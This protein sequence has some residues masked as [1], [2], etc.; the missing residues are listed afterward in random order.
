MDTAPSQPD[1]G[2]TTYPLKVLYVDDEDDIREIAVMA[3]ELDPDILVKSCESGA[4]ALQAAQAWLPD[5]ILLDVMMPGM[6][7][8]E[9]FAKLRRH[10]ATLAIPVVFITARTQQEDIERF[11]ALGAA[12]VIS[13]PFDPM[14]L[15]SEAKNLLAVTVNS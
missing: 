7:G 2:G 3:L 6:D 11:M 13:K 10:P 8:P 9:T 15:A 14:A 1:R 4:E 5:L 12:G